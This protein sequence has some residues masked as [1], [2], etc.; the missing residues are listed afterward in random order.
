[1]LEWAGYR[2]KV[3]ECVSTEHTAKNLLIA[4]IKVRDRGTVSDPAAG[5]IRAFAQFYG[6]GHHQLATHL[7][8]TF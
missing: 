3:F 7:G 6:I 5:K 4:A 1:L 2:A 8:F